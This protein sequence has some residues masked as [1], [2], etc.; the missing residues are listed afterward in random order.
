MT[1]TTRGFIGD[2]GVRSHPL[3]KMRRRDLLEAARD[4]VGKVKDYLDKWTEQK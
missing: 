3:P 1:L 2:Y 4:F